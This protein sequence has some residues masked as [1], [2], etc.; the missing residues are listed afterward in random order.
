MARI[1]GLRGNR[2]IEY[3]SN[4]QWRSG[5]E[6]PVVDHLCLRLVEQQGTLQRNAC[7]GGSS[8][9]AT[10][11]KIRCQITRPAPAMEAVVRCRT[12]GRIPAHSPASDI[13][14]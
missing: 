9:P 4:D 8:D 1:A 13:R 6:R 2:A 12:R 7:S 10:V 3:S 14:S 5:R 11:S